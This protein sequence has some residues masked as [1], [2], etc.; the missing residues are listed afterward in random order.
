M[1]TIFSG[2][3]P[4][5]LEPTNYQSTLELL[6]PG[7]WNAIDGQVYSR[8]SVFSAY[9]ISCVAFLNRYEFRQNEF[10]CTVKNVSLHSKSHASGQ[11]DFIAVGT[12]VYR[13]ED[14]AAKGGAS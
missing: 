7:S 1:L 8:S 11:R 12:T 5:L 6:V 14:L 9:S 10:V 4:R 2:S 3:A 13:G